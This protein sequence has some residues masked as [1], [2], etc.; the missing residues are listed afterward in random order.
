[1][2]DVRLLQGDDGVF[3]VVIE[4]GDLEAED[5][6]ETAI[7]ISLLIDARAP[8]SI[9]FKPENRRGWLGNVA[10]PVTGRELGGLLWLIEQSRLNQGT[11]NEAV[12]YARQALNWFVEDGLAEKV[13]VSGEI[14]P[15]SGITLTIVITAL[16]GKTETHY[17]DL[18]EVTGNG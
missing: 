16:N 15:R 11:L 10:T 3:D 17:V 4:N 5:G 8:S 7:Y 2:S 6:F 18:W 12:S 1:M 14:V 13:E 9:V